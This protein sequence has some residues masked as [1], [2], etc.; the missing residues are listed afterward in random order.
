MAGYSRICLVRE[1][2]VTYRVM[3]SVGSLFLSPQCATSSTR[4][5]EGDEELDRAQCSLFVHHEEDYK[6]VSRGFQV[7][8]VARSLTSCSLE[9]EWARHERE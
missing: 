2:A 8:G 7:S 1:Q 9:L 3:L 6:F 5:L 4:A